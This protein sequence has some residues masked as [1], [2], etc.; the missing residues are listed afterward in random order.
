MAGANLTTASVLL[1]ERYLDRIRE[2]INDKTKTLTR[3]TRSSNGVT[4]EIGGK[5][6]TFAIHT[7]RN[8]GIGSRYED[9]ALPI[10]GSQGNAAARVGLKYAYGGVR[11]TGPVIA[12][13][14]TNPQAFTSV[15]T[16]ET[17]RLSVDLRKDLN[18]QVY[19]DGTGAIATVKS[20]VT[21]TTIPVDDAKM[22]Q[23]GE[24]VDLVNV[25]AGTVAQAARTVNAV[26]LT[27]GANTVT[28][29]GAAITTTTSPVQ[30]FTRTGSS[31]GASGNRELTGFKAAVSATTVYENIDPAVEPEWTSE[32]S[33]N[34]GTNRA[35]TEGLMIALADRIQ[36]RGGST[37]VIFTSRGVRRSYFNLLSQ[38]RQT[39][40]TQKFTGGFSGL[41]FETDD[42]EIPVVSDDDAPLSKMWFLNE[43]SFTFY[44][45]ADWDW[46]DRDGE[47]WKMDQTSGSAKDAWFAYLH[48][49]HELGCDRRNTNG[50]LADIT[51]S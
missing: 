45:E 18:R 10:P 11:L 47:M 36:T 27:V 42:G 30:I 26:D 5:Y 48:R 1:K 41:A 51:E 7:R 25:V 15:L 49:Y 46:L 16:Q 2:Q 19:Q 37:S 39:V 43:S 38:T 9:E 50:Q 33:A 23:I 44:Q 34:G 17:D 4:S 20:V 28:V 12:L 32:I 29:S 40:N 24:I 6:V 14:K 13:T 31:V 22:F 3:I 8:N 35:L 21:S